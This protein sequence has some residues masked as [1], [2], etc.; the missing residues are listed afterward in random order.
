VAVA[1]HSL[2]TVGIVELGTMTQIETQHTLSI[3]TL[4]I[5]T[6]GIMTL[7]IMTIGIMTLGT[8]TLSIMARL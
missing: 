8:V 1:R 5:M 3:M 2:T 7:G 4:G 6:L